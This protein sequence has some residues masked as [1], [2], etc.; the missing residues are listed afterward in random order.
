MYIPTCTHIRHRYIR[1]CM[2]ESGLA[3]LTG[4][5]EEAKLRSERTLNAASPR[6]EFKFR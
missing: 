1:R 5:L 6:F 4:N 2:L 3:L